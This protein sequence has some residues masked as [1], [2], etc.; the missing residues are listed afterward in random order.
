MNAE[1]LQLTGDF[2]IDALEYR[3]ADVPEP[4]ADEVL[5][6]I[7]AVSLNYRDLMV[8]RGHY[9]P[10]VQKPLTLCSDCSGQVIAVGKEVRAFKPG[11]RVMSSFFL[12]WQD[13]PITDAVVPS[14]LGDAQGGVLTTARTFPA[15]SLVAVPASLSHEEASCLPCAGGE[16]PYSV[17]M[18]LLDLGLSAERFEVVAVDVSERSIVRAAR[19]IYGTSSFRGVSEATRSRYFEPA[20]PAGRYAHVKGPQAGSYQ[21]PQ[22]HRVAGQVGVELVQVA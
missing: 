3:Q 14:A 17:V 22:A 2:S 6:R 13:G 7:R 9:N 5:V 12:D 20:E 21:G 15:H 19:G 16:E 11:D 18:T 4:A 10:R 1:A 8:V